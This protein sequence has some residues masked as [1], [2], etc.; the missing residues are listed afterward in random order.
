MLKYECLENEVWKICYLHN[1]RYS[2][3]NFGRVRNNEKQT[4]LTAHFSAKKYKIVKISNII[5]NS[6]SKN[7][8]IHRLVAIYFIPNTNNKPQVNHKD[9]NKSNNNVEN[10]E[11]FTCAENIKHCWEN[12]LNRAR[13]GEESKSSKLTE[14]EVFAIRVMYSTD[15]FTM[16]ELSEIFNISKPSINLILRNV[17]WKEDLIN[18]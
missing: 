3:S 14:K 2:V 12:N 15:K 4:L 7:I 16:Q 9:G 10:L 17:N 6:G 13:K 18:K 11:W 1:E 8:P 5:N